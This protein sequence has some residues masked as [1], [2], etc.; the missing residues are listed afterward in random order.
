MRQQD[1]EFEDSPGYIA[2][3]CLKIC[4]HPKQTKHPEYESKSHYMDL[5]GVKSAVT[6]NE[7]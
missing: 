3:P 7:Q 5:L 1:H 4:P 6:D 2:R